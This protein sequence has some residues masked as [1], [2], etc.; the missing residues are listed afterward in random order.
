V[1]GDALESFAA[2]LLPFHVGGGGTFREAVALFGSQVR[3]RHGF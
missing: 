1:S 2:N 3:E